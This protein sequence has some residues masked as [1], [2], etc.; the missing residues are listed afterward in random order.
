MVAVNIREFAHHLS[1]YLKTT[2]AGERV[3]IM[4]RNKPIVDLVPHNEHLIQPGWKRKFTRIKLKGEAMSETIVRM[5]EEED[6]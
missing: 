6:R 2:K 1:K 5:R 3:V 4:E